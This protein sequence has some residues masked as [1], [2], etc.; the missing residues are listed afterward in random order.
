MNKG[1]VTLAVLSLLLVPAKPASSQQDTLPVV[2]IGFV[3][4][5]PHEDNVEFSEM[6]ALEI[7]AV[8]EGEF[9]VRFPLE[10]R[11]MADHT[12]AGVARGVSEML[13]DPEVDLLITA[14]PLGSYEVTRRGPLPKPTIAPFVMDPEVMGLPLIEGTSGVPNLTYVAMATEVTRDF[15]AFREVVPFE[16]LTVLGNP[17]WAEA[18]PAISLGAQEAAQRLGI[19]LDL[20]PVDAPIEE[21]LQAV[22]PDAQAVYVTPLLHLT[23]G[24]WDRLVSELN[25]RRLPTFSMLGIEEVERGVLATM[26]PETFFPQVTRRVALNIQRI[27]LGEEPGSLPVFFDCGERM[28]INMETAR[29]IGRFPNWDVLTEAELLNYEEEA[30]DR[31]LSISLVAHE[32]QEANLDLIVQDGIVSAGAEE[33]RLAR[34]VLLPQVEASAAG[35]AIDK[36]RAEASFGSQAERTVSGRVTLTQLLYSDPAWANFSVQEDLQ[37]ARRHARE[38]KRM[39][40]ILDAVTAYLDVLQTRA[41]ARI[42]RENVVATRSNLELARVRREIGT[43]RAGEVLRW[44]SQIAVDRNRV[45]SA[46][47]QR[48]ASEVA[49]NRLLHRPQEERFGAEDLRVVI[50]P[51]GRATTTDPSLLTSDERLAGYGMNPLAW[52]AFRNFMV[53]EG[54]A[55]SPEIEQLDAAISAQER[56]YQ[57]STRAFWAPTVALQGSLDNRFSRAGAGSTGFQLQEVPAG[58]PTFPTAD[59]VSWNL[60]LSFSIPIFNGGSK[61]AAR[62]Q[63]SETLRHLQIQRQAVAER[64]EQRIRSAAFAMGSSYMNIGLSAEAA[65][66]ARENLELVRSAYAQGAVSIIELLDAQNAALAADEAAAIAVYVF[67]ANHVRVQRAIGRFDFFM[68]EA[69]REAYFRR[70]D[71]YFK[72]VGVVPAYRD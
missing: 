38:E 66:A 63:A 5:G 10:K 9:D 59:D 17:R 62:T 51:D 15:Q 11:R 14:G 54:L 65:R 69:E 16:T 21:A 35:S 33:V 3:Q 42:Q 43:A 47:A 52:D 31:V 60:S 44:E 70:L 50:R 58:F 72:R 68:T 24:E 53:E 49:L 46:D 55:L 6:Y 40:V 32:A 7:R 27:L 30:P 20:I 13:A 34:S 71:E 29:T 1:A 36:D 45:I 39:D 28:T 41:I 56:A 26:R 67:A 22:P 19:E 61:W 2:R 64:I 18:I 4:D 23:R 8:L 57:S 25:R 12:L 37:T 48:L